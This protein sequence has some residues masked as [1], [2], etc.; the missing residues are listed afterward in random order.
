MQ[1]IKF[2]FTSSSRIYIGFLVLLLLVLGCANRG[3]PTGGEQDILPPEIVKT[4][5]EN[6]STNFK[7]EEIRVYFNEYVKIKDLNKQLIVSPPMDTNPE[8]TPQG[9]ASKYITI[10]IKDTLEA[11]TTYALNFGTSIVDNNEE[12]PYP[13]YRYVFS[14]GD[15]IDS[16]SVK[17]VVFDAEKRQPDAFIS[18]GLY[19]ADTTFKDSTVYKKKPKYVTNTLDSLTAF[20]IDNIK[21]GSYKLIAIK[22][23]NSNFTFEPAQDKIG[24]YEGI[25][26]V[27]T[28]SIYEITL[29]KEEL[30]FKIIRPAQIAEQ[31][32][33]FPFQGNPDDTEI[34]IQND[35]LQDFEYRITRDKETDSLYYWYKPK[36]EL[37]STFF[38]VNNKIY[39]DTLKHKFRKADL[40]DSLTITPLKSGNL[41]FYEVFT[42][43]GST[44]FVKID[45]TKI[46]LIDKDSVKVAYKV[47]LDEVYNQYKF[48]FELKEEQKYKMQALPNAFTDFYG[49]TNDT[50]NFSFGTRKK[51]DFGNIRVSL[52]N[53]KFPLIVQLVDD[54]GEVMYERYTEESPTVDFTDIIPRKYFIRVIFDTNKN[55]RFDSGNYLKKRQAER[56]SYHPSEIDVRPNFDYNETLTLQD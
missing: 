19:E 50:L 28:D 21:A 8:I 9:S 31:R 22:D 52:I 26:T 5:P 56:I 11:N 39:T 14:T 6:Y 48:P 40:V 24:F 32:I 49:K 23:E 54:K 25:V 27:P 2:M 42:L 10:K 46:N 55:K 1:I 51:E 20:S 15:V 43:E 35:T 41:N 45:T 3:R 38:V 18:V 29:F 16:L 44:P 36:L 7:A 30:D 17:G 12:N 34:I 53:A 33:V 37:D 47:E 13:Y 4:I